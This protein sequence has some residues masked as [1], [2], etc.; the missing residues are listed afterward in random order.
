MKAK[1]LYYT[2]CEQG[3]ENGAGFQIKAKSNN[4]EK[5]DEIKQLGNYEPPRDYPSM[6][7]QKELEHFPI[8]FKY[9]ENLFARSKYVGQ[10]YTGRYG[11]FF[12]HGLEVNNVD[13]YPIDMYFWDKWIENEKQVNSLNLPEIEISSIEVP[14]LKLENIEIL[15]KII[16]ILFKKDKKIVIK[17]KNQIDGINLIYFIQKAFSK[18]ISKT[19][20]FSS[21]QFSE[22]DCLD[23]NIVVGDTEFE[24]ADKSNYYY[25]DLTTNQYPEIQINNYAKLVI[26]V[27]NNPILLHRYHK[28]FEYFEF[29]KI[30]D[31]LAYV[32]ELFLFIEV[33][34]ELKSLSE[35]LNFIVNSAKKEY[36]KELL[37]KLSPKID[38]TTQLSDI[39]ALLNF[40]IVMFSKDVIDEIFRI[41]T[42]LFNNTLKAKYNF[43][44]IEKFIEKL[45]TKNSN[46]ESYFIPYF[47]KQIELDKIHLLNSDEFV[48]VINKLFKYYNIA[49]KDNQLLKDIIIN[50]INVNKTISP[51]IITIFDNIEQLKFII[52]ISDILPKK[53]INEI[54]K[55]FNNL[56]N[57]NEYYHKLSLMNKNNLNPYFVITSFQNKFLVVE[58]KVSFFTK[59]IENVEENSEII[60]WYYKNLSLQDKILQIKLWKDQLEVLEDYSFFTD[61]YQT[62]NKN[63]F[64][65]FRKDAEFIKLYYDK[66]SYIK[67]NTPNR[68]LLREII[69]DYTKIHK[70]IYTEI[71]QL[72]RK[73]YIYLINNFFN[74]LDVS[75]IKSSHF[76]YL[77]HQSYQKD[78]YD[79]FENLKGRL[80]V[81]DLVKFYLDGMGEIEQKIEEI[82]ILILSNQ[83]NEVIDD[84][85]D[86]ADTENKKEKLQ[87]LVKKAN[88]KLSLK[89]V[90]KIIKSLFTKGK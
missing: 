68:F 58:N 85:Q 33:N 2:S 5:T 72:E 22:I 74:Q 63:L 45:N 4:F 64:T 43:V 84:L 88:K 25:F 14:E 11:N 53:E 65:D 15:E 76:Q 67:L 41:L 66:Y 89:N 21:Y 34:Y 17:V 51:N 70:N 87:K 1:Q 30:D 35:I 23:I 73:E 31:N 8:L 44:E 26:Q 62:I 49:N 32:L 86:L 59:F 12:L 78:F 60:G 18:M 54:S 39:E 24:Y 75:S 29:S 16:T 48:L 19:I 69:F 71:N 57:G 36:L 9:K 3:L 46:F 55:V 13:I 81:K 20:T 50:Y 52:E 38:K 10:D 83:S 28:F 7:S 90:S 42:L 56:Y 77:L 40:Y 27:L 82:L 47:L 79:Y 37:E 80:S 6:P 61:I